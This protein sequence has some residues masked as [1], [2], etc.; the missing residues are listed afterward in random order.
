MEVKLFAVN[1]ASRLLLDKRFWNDCKQF[2][3]NIDGD[4]NLTGEEKRAKVKKD[5]L[6]VFGD[7]ASVIVHLGIELAVAWL[8]LQSPKSA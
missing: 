6:T 1:I 5:L 2:V 3:S 8:K 7:V 4:T